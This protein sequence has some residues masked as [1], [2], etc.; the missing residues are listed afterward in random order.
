MIDVEDVSSAHSLLSAPGAS[1]ATRGFARPPS[2][3]AGRALHVRHAGDGGDAQH[4]LLL[5]RRTLQLAAV[6]YDPAGDRGRAASPASP[7][8]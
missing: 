6:D 3:A 7:R 5:A 4:D 2:S 1:A 8:E